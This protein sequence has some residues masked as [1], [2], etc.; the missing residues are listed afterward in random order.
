MIVK[1]NGFHKLGKYPDCFLR[2]SSVSEFDDCD[3]FVLPLNLWK[4]LICLYP[5]TTYNLGLNFI[6]VKTLK[7]EYITISKWYEIIDEYKNLRYK[8]LSYH[9]YV[10]SPICKNDLRAIL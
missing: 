3:S 5:S 10:L 4:F 6:V 2:N 7:K 1:V 9:L 8:K